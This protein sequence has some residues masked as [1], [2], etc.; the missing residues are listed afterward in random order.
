MLVAKVVE[1]SVVLAD[2]SGVLGVTI[3]L[4]LVSVVVGVSV[5]L[6]LV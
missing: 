5:V 3:L 6:E 1:V 4:I 2:D